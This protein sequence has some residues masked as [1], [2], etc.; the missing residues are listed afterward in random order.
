MGGDRES[1]DDISRVVCVVECSPPLGLSSLGSASFCSFVGK[2]EWYCI[3]RR[4][5]LDPNASGAEGC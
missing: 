4:D 5:R 1:S 3:P 2:V